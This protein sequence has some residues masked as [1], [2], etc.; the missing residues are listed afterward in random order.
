MR[1]DKNN[2]AY[3]EGML[4][5]TSYGFQ[6]IE[7]GFVSVILGIGHGCELD[8]GAFHQVELRL[9]IPERLKRDLRAA[10]ER[11][12]LARELRPINDWQ[13]DE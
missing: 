5:G 7:P 3:S 11:G 4:M 2:C 13:P 9:P 1:Q 10:S 6:S 8:R 12:L